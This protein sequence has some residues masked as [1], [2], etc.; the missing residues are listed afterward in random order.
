MY[1][2]GHLTD[3][4]GEATVYAD[5]GEPV[6]R[7]GGMER[8]CVKCGLTADHQGPDPC[9][10]HLPGVVAACCG[11]GNPRQSAYLSFE[12]GTKVSLFIHGRNLA[13]AGEI[14]VERSQLRSSSGE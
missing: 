1:Y 5:T 11:H 7:C 6:P 4:N 10:G 9:L 12:N 2:R 8:P 13:G 3:W 14:E